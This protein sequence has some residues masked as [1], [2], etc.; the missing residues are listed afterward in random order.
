M[1]NRVIQAVVPAATATWVPGRSSFHSVMAL[2]MTALVLSIIYLAQ[3]TEQLP[4]NQDQV[5]AS[6]ASSIDHNGRLSS[7][8]ISPPPPPLEDPPPP[9]KTSCDMFSGKWVFDNISYP[10]YRECN[11]MSFEPMKCEN[12]GRKDLTYQNWRWQ[13][14]NCDLPR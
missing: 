10:M 8:I 5:N 4:P 1:A 14:H 13:P 6:E 7:G 12:F 3:D 9:E 11:I 2:L